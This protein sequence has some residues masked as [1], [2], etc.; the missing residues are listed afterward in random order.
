[1][2]HESNPELI[3]LITDPE[4]PERTVTGMHRIASQ[5]TYYKPTFNL[6]ALTNNKTTSF[7]LDGK[8]LCGNIQSYLYL[9][10]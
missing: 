4:A 8:I 1:M 7:A 10:G 2:G 5:F 9:L 3:K 6:F